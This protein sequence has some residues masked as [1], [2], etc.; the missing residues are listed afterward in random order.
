MVEAVDEA[1]SY[2]VLLKS[3]GGR[4]KLLN[5]RK[6]NNQS[7]VDAV[8]IL[9]SAYLCGGNISNKSLKVYACPQ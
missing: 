7:I 3:K 4:H 2:V 5:F 8:G 9:Y 6:Q 1:I